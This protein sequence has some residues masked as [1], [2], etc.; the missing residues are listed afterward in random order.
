[1]I[2]DSNRK[3]WLTFGDPDTDSGSLFHFPHHCGIGDF[4][5]FISISHSHRLIFTT[6]SKVTE[7]N[8]LMNS[9]HFGSDPAD[10]RIQIWINPEI[11][12][13]IP[14]RFWLIDV[15]CLGGG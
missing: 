4:R 12:I 8:K 6:L 3:N 7:T 11:Q 2:G 15:K 1:M 14:Y 9:Q 13:R 5:R 10:I